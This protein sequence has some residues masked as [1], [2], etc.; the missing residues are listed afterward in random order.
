MYKSLAN[1]R[2]AMITHDYVQ[3]T[4]NMQSLLQAGV[5]IDFSLLIDTYYSNHLGYGMRTNISPTSHS[6]PSSIHGH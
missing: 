2:V 4:G 3:E 6:R 5:F 1:Y